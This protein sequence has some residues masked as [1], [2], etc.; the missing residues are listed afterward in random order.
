MSEARKAIQAREWQALYDKILSTLG[1]FGRDDPFG[2]GDYY[3]L[4]E[5]W[6]WHVHQ[7]EV[8][9]L[10]LFQPTC[11]Y[12]LQELLAEY[13]DWE[14]AVRVVTPETVDT[15]PVMGVVIAGDEII[16]EL[17]R[18]YLPAEFRDLKYGSSK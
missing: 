14:I 18:E 6:G 5:N 1:R 9:N 2:K 8:Q 10:A 16:D 15:W 4:D 11:I 17:Q 7:L 12:A 3:L 13:P